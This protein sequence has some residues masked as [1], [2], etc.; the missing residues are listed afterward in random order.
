[1]QNVKKTTAW[2]VLFFRQSAFSRSPRLHD[3]VCGSPQWP[4]PRVR[5]E[6]D[7]AEA[8]DEDNALARENR[9][10]SRA[11][12]RAEPTSRE[13]CASRRQKSTRFA[14]TGIVDVISRRSLSLL[15]RSRSSD[16]S[17][18]SDDPSGQFASVDEARALIA[19]LEKKEE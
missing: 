9:L 6:P 14:H 2:S 17:C 4:V 7:A 15:Y 10:L 13:K 11:R 5:P 3:C 8:R 18:T 12:R 16:R 19:R 1:M